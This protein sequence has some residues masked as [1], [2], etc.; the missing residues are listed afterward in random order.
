VRASNGFSGGYGGPAVLAR[1]ARGISNRFTAGGRLEAEPGVISG[2][3]SAV[4]TIGVLAGVLSINASGAGGNTGTAAALQLSA[5]SRGAVAL[6]GSLQWQSLHYATSSLSPTQ[7]RALFEAQL[8]ASLL[9][10]RSSSL[11]VSIFN[12]VPSTGAPQS[13]L[14]VGLSQQL[15]HQLSLYAQ[16]TRVR[17]NS[18]LGA[19]TQNAFSLNLQRTIGRRDN[20][21]IRTSA[22]S[23]SG[24]SSRTTS[25]S[26]SHAI[27]GAF[28]LGYDADAGLGNTRDLS[29]SAN[30]QGSLGSAQA[31]FSTF[32]GSSSVDLSYAGGLAY[33]QKHVFLT[34]TIEDAY[35]LVEVPGLAGAEVY[36]N[37]R[38]EGRTDRSGFLLLPDLVS[39]L[40]NDVHVLLP[41]N[42]LDA[43]ITG[44]TTD[45][46]PDFRSAVTFPYEV[47][48]VQAI[49]LS[50]LLQ[51]KKGAAIVPEYGEF[52]LT[53]ARGLVQSSEI[54]GAGRAYFN[55]LLPGRYSAEIEYV[56]QRCRFVLDIPPHDQVVLDLGVKT[57][58]E[59]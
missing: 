2:G 54:D 25:I 17:G 32:A 36:S 11:S 29:A 34:R 9:L 21:G 26:F 8:D 53:S 33:I 35:G 14:T 43:T 55:E 22:S 42:V 52:T 49:L 28:G 1:Y 46:I 20:V 4:R 27:D 58:T 15:G 19:V 41:S 16:A 50:L 3:L 5:P 40:P 45:V 23:G 24:G 38:M 13:A 12:T 47:Q 6:G 39:Q 56:S 18:L 37:G 44:A 59:R 57:C 30:Y 10:S 51:A 7:G 48:R 31:F